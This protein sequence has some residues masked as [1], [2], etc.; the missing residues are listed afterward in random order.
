MKYQNLFLSTLVA[1]LWLYGSAAQAV[2]KVFACEPEWASLTEELAGEHADVFQATTAFQDPHHIDAR[3]SLIA[4]MRRADLVVC[5]GADLEV[6]WLPLL[7]RSAGNNKIQPGTDGY[8]EAAMQVDRLDVPTSLDRSDGDVHAAGNPHVHLDPRRVLVIA[9]KLASRLALIDPANKKHYENNRNQFE[10]K[11]NAMLSALR[12]ATE[13]IAGKS[14]VV[15]HNDWSYLFD[16]LQLKSHTTIESKP[17]IPP[18]SRDLKRLL[19]AV[20]GQSISGIILAEYQSDRAAKWLSK[21]SGIPVIK[22]PYTV[23]GDDK[24]ID[25]VSLYRNSL[26][27]L[28]ENK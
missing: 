17:G 9:S 11:I 18:S 7:I 21:K 20:K 2:I 26:E 22:L 6:G 25:L 5:N 19:A 1:G 23:G 4:K 16:W 14:Y 24:S 15:Y 8:F 27:R 12:N 28:S 13:A 3:P 10:S